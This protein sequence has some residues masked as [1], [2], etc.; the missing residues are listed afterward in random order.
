RIVSRPGPRSTPG[1]QILV[2]DHALPTPDLDAG[3]LRMMEI[4]KAM[5]RRGHPVAFIPDS[6]LLSTPY[7][8]NLQRIGV[9]IVHQP[10][11]QSATDYL[12]QHGR[13]FDLVIISRADIA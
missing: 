11:Y 8:Q 10:D 3:S 1:R 2:I 4:L 5:R 6:M 9:E 7:D 12:V 13:G